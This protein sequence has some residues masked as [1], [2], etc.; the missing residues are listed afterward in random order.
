MLAALP[1]LLYLAALAFTN[2]DCLYPR[3]PAAAPGELMTPYVSVSGATAFGFA[4]PASSDARRTVDPRSIFAAG[5]E[6]PPGVMP[7]I[8]RM[9]R[10]SPTFRR[11]CARLIGAGAVVRLSFQQPSKAAPPAWSEISRA[12]KGRLAAHIRL[13][14]LD[15]AVARYLAHEVEHV[16]EQIDHVDLQGAVAS[17]LHG[18]HVV[19]PPNTFE[20]SRATAMGHAVASEVQIF[21]SRR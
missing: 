13:P 12:N 17:R 5:F 20:T 8:D 2:P 3:Q 6:I 21:L 7:L 9:W 16:L 1:V 18:A 15:E 10:A 19:I 11:Q 4:M 14:R